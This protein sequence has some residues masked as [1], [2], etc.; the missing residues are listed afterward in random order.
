M[1]GIT[2]PRIFT[3]PLREL[4]PE[5]SLGYAFA[6]WCKAV[7]SVELLPWQEWLA[8]HSLE[9]LGDFE[10]S[11]QFR[12]RTVIV[13]IARQN[14]KSLVATLLAL[15]FMYVLGVDLVL[16]TAQNLETAEEV[17]DDA[18]STAESSP[19]LAGMIKTVRRVNGGKAL[20]LTNGAKYKIVA[21]TRQGARGKSSDLVIM[22]ELRE[23]RNW[24]GWSAVSKTTNAKPNGILF[25]FSNAGDPTSVVLRHKRMTAHAALGDPDGIAETVLRAMPEDDGGDSTLAIFEWSAPPDC[26]MHD[27]GAIAQANPSLG[28]GFMTWRA[29]KSS[30]DEPEHV[31]RPECLC[32]W[33][34]S[35]V[36]SPFPP[37][38]WE[39]TTDDESFEDET[40]PKFWGLDMSADRTKCALAFVAK[41][42]DGEWHGEVEAYH[43]GFE[44]MRSL[45]ARNA[46]MRIAVQGRGAPI[47]AHIEELQRIEGVDVVLCEGRDVG[48][49]TGRFYEAIT[50][51]ENGGVPLWHITQPAL[52]YA[53]RIA[54]TRPLGEA[55]GWDRRAS[56]ADIS[57]LVALTM[58][59]GLATGGA[60]ERPYFP[61]AY[62]DRGVRVI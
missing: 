40:A 18:V 8:V 35:V 7:C 52:D 19:A 16:G 36:R 15:F 29:L 13:L 34:E 44:W 39:S 30:L 57:P 49:W 3:P 25:G 51:H 60:T 10:T 48:A 56:E 61:S 26:E 38:A 4:T 53:A 62:A 50:A 20:E 5:T 6:D 45:I 21:A 37:D 31:F 33:V 11:W 14:G 23:Q 58:A 54:Q 55:F 28:Y 32:Q 9:I 42:D 2:Q 47:S 41:R 17:W 46:P 12:F 1:K 24:D 27:E 22:D 59:F 43:A